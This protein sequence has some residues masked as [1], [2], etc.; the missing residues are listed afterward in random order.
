[1]LSKDNGSTL[2]A[3][4]VAIAIVVLALTYILASLSASGQGSALIHRRTMAENLARQQMELIKAAAFSAT[5]DYA[6]AAVAPLDGYTMAWTVN[7]WNGAAFQ[8]MPTADG[9][10]LVTVTVSLA[11]SGR[12]LVELEGYKADR[13]G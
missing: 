5:G 3:D 8:E 10:Q 2:I 13:E 7:H 6:G 12:T 4:L 9:M 11:G 1:M